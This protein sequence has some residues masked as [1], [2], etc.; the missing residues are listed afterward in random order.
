MANAH[1]PLSH[2][3][4]LSY[5]LTAPVRMIWS[6]LIALSESSSRMKAV[7]ELNTLSDEELAAHGMTRTDAVRRIF[8]DNYAS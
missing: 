8:N 6:A 4:G 2:R 3:F 1:E 5:I 7:H